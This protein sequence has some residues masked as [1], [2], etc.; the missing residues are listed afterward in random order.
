MQK[1]RKI[2]DLISDE[3]QI[4]SPTVISNNYNNVKRKVNTFLWSKLL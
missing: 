4:K 1:M 2:G 3:I